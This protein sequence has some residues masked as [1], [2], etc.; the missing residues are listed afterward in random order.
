MTQEIRISL[1]SGRERAV[2]QASKPVRTVKVE[3]VWEGD[4]RSSIAFSGLVVR[5]DGEMRCK[6]SHQEMERVLRG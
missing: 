4:H 3:R 6:I 1:P 5:R 2:R